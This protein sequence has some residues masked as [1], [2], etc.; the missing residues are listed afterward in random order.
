MNYPF[1]NCSLLAGTAL[2]VGCATQGNIAPRAQAIDP[3]G[4]DAGSV[5]DKAAIGSAVDDA[6]WTVYRDAQLNSLVAQAVAGNPTLRIA[7]D[8]IAQAESLAGA[9][10]AAMMP[11]VGGSAEF[12]RL[13]FSE[14]GETP[15]PLA[16]GV[17]WDNNIDV[18]ASFDLDLWGRDRA[19]LE[20]ALGSLRAAQLDARF[21]TLALQTSVVRSYLQLS[22]AYA[23]QDV[24]TATVTQREHVLDLTR[25][26]QSAGLAP[27]LQVSQAEAEV[28]PVR[29][30][31]EQSNNRIVTL[32]NQLAA[33]TG[34]GPGAGEA[35][36]RPQVSVTD[37]A[38]LPSVVP[39]DL[40]GRR[41]DIV[42]ARWRI[43]AAGKGIDVAK[44][45]FY[46]DVNLSAFVG[47]QALS[48]EHLFEGDARVLGAGPAITLPIFEGGRLR[49]NLAGRTAVYDMAVDQYNDSVIGAMRDVADQLA[50][51]ESTARQHAQAEDA[52]A[53]AQKAY[54]QAQLGFHAGLT[55]F[56]TVLTTQ[57][58]LLTQQQELAQIVAAQLDAR[59]VLMQA[60]GGGFHDQDDSAALLKRSVD[61]HPSAQPQAAP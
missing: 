5:I 34:Q 53:A 58:A 6:W 55:D 51:V 52:L 43:E 28:A 39:A 16:G 60:L 8:R 47:L 36:T 1:I 48:F 27:L 18:K 21:S 38:T 44:A 26:R 49:A 33:L 57:T 42:A 11:T 50:T 4:I 2:L 46:P 3:A 15:P 30:R 45:Q 29:V 12:Q 40:I 9:A 22:Y 56:L 35:L 13:H 61:E 32:R 41:P 59:A 24:L 31:L 23:L 37:A 25:R 54:D 17:S 14:V 10:H 7:T 20:G 19:A